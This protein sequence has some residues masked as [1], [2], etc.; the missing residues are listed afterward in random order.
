MTLVLHFLDADSDQS[1]SLKL[2]S[3]VSLDRSAPL[4]LDLEILGALRSLPGDWSLAAEPHTILSW[5]EEGAL[6]PGSA[7]LWL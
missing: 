3:P 2:P 5:E 4:G 7:G 6:S 1:L